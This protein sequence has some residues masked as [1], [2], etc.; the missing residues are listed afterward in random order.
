MNKFHLVTVLY[1]IPIPELTDIIL[2]CIQ[3]IVYCTH[4]SSWYYHLNSLLYS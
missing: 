4:A 2:L 3:S 1:K